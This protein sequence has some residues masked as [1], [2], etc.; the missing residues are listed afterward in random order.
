VKRQVR[1]PAELAAALKKNKIAAKAF[2]QF[3]PSCQREYTD[4][5]TEA[6][7]PETKKKR[8]ARALEWIAQAKP[9]HWKYKNC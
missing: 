9:R 5:I 8:L 7:R 4:W 6:K 2:E 1:V 3:S